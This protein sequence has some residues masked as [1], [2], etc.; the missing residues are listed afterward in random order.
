MG[1]MKVS[2]NEDEV[3]ACSC[4]GRVVSTRRR[5]ASPCRTRPE[6]VSPLGVK[7]P[8]C[9]PLPI[10]SPS[11]TPLRDVLMLNKRQSVS[12]NSAS[13]QGGSS[14]SC[15][16]LFVLSIRVA[17]PRAGCVHAFFGACFCAHH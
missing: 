8:R 16:S 17:L 15:L 9:V 14:L 12:S 13:A 1:A 4:E 10:F 2:S 5:R 11:L 7:Y 6:S 3:R